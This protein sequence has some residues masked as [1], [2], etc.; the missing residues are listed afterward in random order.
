M[1]STL[2][3]YYV[4]PG[5]G[6]DVTGTGTVGSPWASVQHALDNIT[7][8][9][10]NGDQ[11]NI[12]AGTAD[13]LSSPAPSE[14]LLLTCHPSCAMRWR[15]IRSCEPLMRLTLRRM[16]AP[17]RRH[18]RCFSKKPRTRLPHGTRLTRSLGRG[19]S[20]R[21]S[22]DDSLSWPERCLTSSRHA[23]KHSG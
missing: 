13:V 9:A 19:S 10:T 5:S 21:C 4:D 6:S 14:M 8:D 7:R 20:G 22:S 15:Q 16:R 23:S 18:S 11:I 3:N 2:T 1:A 12:K 17:W